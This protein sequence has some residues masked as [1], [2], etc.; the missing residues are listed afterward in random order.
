M[1]PSIAKLL[2]HHRVN[3]K[4]HLHRIAT[5]LDLNVAKDMRKP[6][7]QCEIEDFLKEELQFEAKVRQIVQSTN[8]LNQ[9]TQTM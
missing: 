9:V 1:S 6:Q 7:I 8:S 2:S 4:D 3:R 5:A